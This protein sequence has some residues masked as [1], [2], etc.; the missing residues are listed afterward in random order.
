M[1]QFGET[2][3]NNTN[4]THK[5][6]TKLRNVLHLAGDQEDLGKS[7]FWP[8]GSCQRQGDHSLSPGRQWPT[9]YQSGSFLAKLPKDKLVELQPAKRPG[10]GG[11]TGTRY[12]AIVFF[13]H[14]RNGKA[15]IITHTAGMKTLWT[16]FGSTSEYVK[17]KKEKFLGNLGRLN[18]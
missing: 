1:L 5:N 16:V 9:R 6:K 14:S 10:E 15:D 13:F 8:H 11:V 12:G 4:T 2:V 17:K 7:Q 3:P 18:Y